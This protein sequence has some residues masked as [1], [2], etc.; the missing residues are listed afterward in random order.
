MPTKTLLLGTPDDRIDSLSSELQIAL[1]TI[2]E[3][4][5]KLQEAE[6]LHLEAQKVACDK[7]EE[8]GRL[9][10]KLQEAEERLGGV[11]ESKQFMFDLIR[12]LRSQLRFEQDRHCEYEDMQANLSQYRDMAEA[13][14]ELQTIWNKGWYVT[15]PKDW[16]S[17]IKRVLTIPIPEEVENG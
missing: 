13:V 1:E 4:R 12:E 15:K 3:Y 8:C 16:N 6:R 10:R 17:A 5:T 11:S 7:S 14:R 9:K 2:R